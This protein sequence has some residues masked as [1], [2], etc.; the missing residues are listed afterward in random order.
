MR[1]SLTAPRL[2]LPTFPI[3]RDMSQLCERLSR[4]YPRRFPR[5]ATNFSKPF[6]T[7]PGTEIFISWHLPD[8]LM[9]DRKVLRAEKRC[10][11][12]STTLLGCTKRIYPP[13]LEHELFHRYQHAFFAYE[14]EHDEP[15]WVRLWAEGMATYVSQTL[16]P[17]ATPMDTMWITDKKLANLDAN[18]GALAASFLHRFDSTARVDA[19]HYF[20]QDV[21]EDP[22]I[23]GHTGYYV[24]TRVAKLLSR[25]YSMV[26][27]AHWTRVQAKA[28]IRD[29]LERIANGMAG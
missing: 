26:E 23:P 3:C 14:P 20:L 8:A 27:M 28:H 7:W 2:Q 13:L 18:A 1:A 25:Q 9:G 24:G 12:G 21:S 17:S 4:L 16:S 29:G 6:L 10:F 5:L 15:M 22:K 11:S 19:D